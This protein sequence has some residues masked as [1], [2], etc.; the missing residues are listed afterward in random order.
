MRRGGLASPR[1][2]GV[3]ERGRGPTNH[4]ASVG[5]WLRH[6]ADTGWT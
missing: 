1:S 4:R 6:G 5:T 3:R 2:D